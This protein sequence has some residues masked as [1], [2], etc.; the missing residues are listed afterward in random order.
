MKTT[1]LLIITV[2]FAS[3]DAGKKT[4]AKYQILNNT[5]HS[6]ALNIYRENK[7]I[8]L[9]NDKGDVWESKEF[10]TSEPGGNFLEPNSDFFIFSDSVV[11]TFDNQRKLI[12]DKTF[13]GI[14]HENN[15]E[16]I[17]DDN[18]TILRFTFTEEDYNNAEDCG[19]KCD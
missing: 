17:T 15:Y 7:E 4:Y 13:K 8:V 2:L 1:V 3:C 14:L 6:V 12:H 10:Q 16:R 9:L 11:V 5:Q 18:L 19:G